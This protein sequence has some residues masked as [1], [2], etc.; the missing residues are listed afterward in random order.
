MAVVDNPDDAISALRKI[1]PDP[2]RGMVIQVTYPVA[3]VI[4]YRIER[5]QLVQ[6]ITEAEQPIA[7]LGNFTA[8]SYESSVD[9][10][11]H[12][13]LVKGDLKASGPVLVR[14][15]SSCPLGDILGVASCD[16]GDQLRESLRRIDEAGRGVLVYLQKDDQPLADLKCSRNASRGQ[17]PAPRFREFGVGAQILRDLGVRKIRLLTNN[18]RKIVG[19]HGFGLTVVDRVPIETKRTRANARYLERK[20]AMGHLISRAARRGSR[21]G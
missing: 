10:R 14:V 17:P 13:A 2:K 21:R 8:V 7:W 9:E 19:L 6:R 16:C 4:R 3:D 1:D 5:E 12:V 11:V 15:H 18:P 20:R